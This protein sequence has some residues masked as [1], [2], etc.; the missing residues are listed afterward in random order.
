[1]ADMMS[2]ARSG[3][4]AAQQ[5]LGATSNNIANVGTEGYNRQVVEQGST[6]SLRQGNHFVGTG[7]YVAD[8]KR[9]YNEF[10]Q[11][12]LSL[13][14]SQ[15][16]QSS[17]SYSKLSEL[18]QIF[19]V[20]GKSVPN[21]LNTLFENVNNLSDMPTDLAVR[22]N[23]LTSADQLAKAFNSINT[24]LSNQLNMQ[25]KQ[26][27]GVVER[28]NAITAELA[29]INGE[30]QK[31]GGQDL[32]LLDQ[33]DRLISELS[34]FVQINTIEQAHGVRSV[35]AGG[36]VMLVSGETATELGTVAGDPIPHQTRLT[37][38]IGG[39][40]VTLRNT[41]LGGQLQG[42]FD[43]RDNELTQAKQ[44]LEL[45]AVGVAD[46]FNQ[47]QANGLD[48]EGNPGE[49]LFTDINDPSLVSRRT[50]PFAGNQSAVSVD[51]RIDDTMAL[52]GGSYTLSFERGGFALIDQHGDS[53]A[54]T[55]DPQDP[56]RLISA[57]GFS[58]HIDPNQ[59][60]QVGDKWQLTPTPGVANGMQML[61]TDP[62][63]VAAAG[64]EG[65]FGP[66]DNSNA[67]A[68]A[69]LANSKLMNQGDM[70]LTDI[71]QNVTTTVG[72]KARAAEVA[73]QSADAVKGQA[74]AR[75]ASES[76]VNLDEEAADMMRFQQAYQAS[77][78]IMT[79]AKET[80]D[81]LFNS[82]R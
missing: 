79:V 30:L 19:S 42:L 63:Q 69:Q 47:A 58:L 12:E 6:A 81:T 8:I 46:A 78:R 15:L 66:G 27:D 59:M 39:Q 53:V 1:M 17:T 65:V 57:Q 50:A 68:M 5:R 37:G 61:L 71:Y 82:V 80:F 9:V 18:D 62:R 51:V 52:S 43:Y 72:G 76:G 55:A 34:E 4:L 75:V 7:T 54:L 33:Q 36:A 2:I 21:S 25:N 40:T 45:M 60:A 73:M 31:V 56:T 38:T 16:S 26:I 14:T 32:Q 23:L 35:M 20:V 11:R 44:Q 10:A 70:T 67:V 41:E 49:N 3:I 24:E 74:E 22:E 13:A 64:N 77:A 29:A 28:V 48:L